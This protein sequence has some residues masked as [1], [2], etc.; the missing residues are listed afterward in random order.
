M[1]K[2]ET[3]SEQDVQYIVSRT[4]LDQI[5]QLKFYVL[6]GQSTLFGHINLATKPGGTKQQPLPL[7][8]AAGVFVGGILATR[9]RP[10]D[11]EVLESAAQACARRTTHSL[12]LSDTPP[13]FALCWS[14]QH[15]SNDRSADR[16]RR[17]STRRARPRRID[18][19]ALAAQPDDL[20]AMAAT[21]VTA[22]SARLPSTATGLSA[23]RLRHP[24]VRGVCRSPTEF[25][26]RSPAATQAAYAGPLRARR[27]A[28]GEPTQGRPITG[29]V[30]SRATRCWLPAN[31]AAAFSA[32]CS[33]S[34]HG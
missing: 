6:R 3:A 2:W 1:H 31:W 24:L 14:R 22:L 5:G 25:K 15:R 8:S 27:T 11:T 33:T 19:Q 9:L 16:R 28:I 34:R 17:L 23:L 32:T 29:S 20:A 18:H 7:N 21:P 10:M 13:W 30:A 12:G 4:T 26:Q